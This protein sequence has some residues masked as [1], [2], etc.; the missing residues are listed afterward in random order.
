MPT[1]WVGFLRTGKNGDGEEVDSDM[2]ALRLETLGPRG[3]RKVRVWCEEHGRLSLVGRPECEKCEARRVRM[4]KRHEK[5]L[6]YC[7]RMWAA[8]SH[9]NAG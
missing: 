2:A 9:E 4:E 8:G 6:E 5:S 1:A 7:R 3:G